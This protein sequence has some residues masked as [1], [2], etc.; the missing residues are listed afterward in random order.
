MR[1]EGWGDR[2]AALGWCSPSP[3]NDQVG[4][5]LPTLRAMTRILGWNL[6]G[7]GGYFWVDD[8]SLWRKMH[9]ECIGTDYMK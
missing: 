7:S 2:E 3:R 9:L 6:A 1:G 8:T 4:A 5:R